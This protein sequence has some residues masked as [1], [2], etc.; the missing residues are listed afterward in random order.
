MAEE[1]AES[2]D[3]R[4]LSWSRQSRA[5]HCLRTYPRAKRGRAGANRGQEAVVSDDSMPEAVEVAEA[6][7]DKVIAEEPPSEDSALTEE[8]AVPVAEERSLSGLDLVSSIID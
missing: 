3:D 1:K 5:S 7:E 6:A 2:E 8:A 4:P